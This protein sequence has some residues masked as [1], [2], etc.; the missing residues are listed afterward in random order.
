MTWLALLTVASILPSMTH[1]Y[2]EDDA[3][4]TRTHVFA[5]SYHWS[6]HSV[7]DALASRVYAQAEFVRA[8]GSAAVDFATAREIRAKAISK[9]IEN[10]VA[11]V[12]AYWDRRAI[13]EAERLKRAHNHLRGLRKR[14]SKTWERFKYHPELS[15]AGIVK[16]TALNFLLHR[17]SGTVLA[18]EFSLAGP[19]DRLANLKELE[20]TPKTLHNLRMRQRLPGGE[21]LIV[22]AGTGEA[23][24][25]DW[26][27]LALRDPQF[28]K[29][30]T[31]FQEARR[32][33]VDESH[34]GAVSPKRIQELDVALL[35]LHGAFEEFYNQK[36]RKLTNFR[37]WSEHTTADSFLKSLIGE[38]GRL[39]ATG[40]VEAFDGSM[41]FP[42]NDLFSLLRFM[43]RHGLDFAPATPGGESAYHEVFKMMRDLYVTASEDDQSIRVDE[44]AQS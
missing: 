9:E 2:A 38:V 15:N 41:K 16:G 6:H 43:S 44:K 35:D 36:R 3:E 33:V 8:S 24:D 42:G 18:Y 39:K 40:S 12:R 32:V 21:R 13:G 20:V 22:R 4:V 26:W 27:P 25:I 11:R 28:D 37:S 19:M 23:L 34:V 29:Q 5:P 1:V 30:R 14:N 31:A 10:S 17:L 7:V